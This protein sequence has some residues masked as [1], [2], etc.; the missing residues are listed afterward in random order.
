MPRQKSP[1]GR[2]RQILLRYRE[3]DPRYATI[4]TALQ[5]VPD[6][7]KNAFL[8]DALVSGL[9]ASR[10]PETA[11]TSNQHPHARENTRIE[12]GPGAASIFQ[13]F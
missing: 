9:G 7:G 11:P 10:V 1:H 6:G 12:Y 8:L 5:S 13:Q 2:M 3:D 4:A